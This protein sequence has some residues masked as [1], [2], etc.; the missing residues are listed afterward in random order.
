MMMNIIILKNLGITLTLSEL[1]NVKLWVYCKT[2][3]ST[4]ELQ[5]L[6][7][8]FTS[9]PLGIKKSLLLSPSNVPQRPQVFS[10]YERL[11]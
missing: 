4:R 10:Q 8:V 7:N 9:S 2:I 1:G 5:G 3:A 11:R 6:I